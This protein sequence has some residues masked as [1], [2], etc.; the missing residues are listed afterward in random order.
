[1]TVS[2]AFES[3]KFYLE[4]CCQEGTV[5]VQVEVHRQTLAEHLLLLEACP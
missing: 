5:V 4:A 1:M 2:A 3:P